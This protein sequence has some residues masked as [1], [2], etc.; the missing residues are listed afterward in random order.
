[1]KKTPKNNNTTK[2][3]SVTF[4]S[5]ESNNRSSKN[6]LTPLRENNSIYSEKSKNT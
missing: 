2:N 5:I 6:S 4:N 1:M 3:G